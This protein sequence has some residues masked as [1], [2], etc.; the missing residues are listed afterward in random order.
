ECK[1]EQKAN[2]ILV[3]MADCHTGGSCHS[4]RVGRPLTHGAAQRNWLYP[5]A[6]RG[7]HRFNASHLFVWRW[8]VFLPQYG[9]QTE[10]N[11]RREGRVGSEVSSGPY[12][13]DPLPCGGGYAGIAKEIV[14]A[15]GQ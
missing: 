9:S 11:R 5:H 6:Q 8:F 14:S 13:N 10:P 15:V 2:E 3:Q 1:V 7:T 12:R 4:V